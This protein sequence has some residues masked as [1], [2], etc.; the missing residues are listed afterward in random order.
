MSVLKEKYFK[1]LEITK[2]TC[3]TQI[4][5]VYTHVF[6]LFTPFYTIFQVYKHKTAQQGSLR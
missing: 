1:Y 6:C 4:T 2:N 5:S 3:S